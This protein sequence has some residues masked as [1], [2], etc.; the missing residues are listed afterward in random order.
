MQ[1]NAT[2]AGL[3][4]AQPGRPYYFVEV[5]EV[6]AKAASP[7]HALPP[8]A[9]YTRTSQVRT[10]SQSVNVSC[11]QLLGLGCLSCLGTRDGPQMV[12]LG[13]VSQ[14]GHGPTCACSRWP[15]DCCGSLLSCVMHY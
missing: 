1:D 5:S 11:S 4:L 7:L 3:P 15:M 9:M 2:S 8:R 10:V 14:R 12:L 6:P 13:Q